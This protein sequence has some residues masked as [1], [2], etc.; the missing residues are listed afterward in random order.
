MT[1]V[2]DSPIELLV[3]RAAGGD[4]AAWQALWSM[5]E[6]LL[7]RMVGQPSFLGRVGQREDDRRNIVVDVMGRL[8]ADDFRR[9]RSYL[10]TRAANPS[11]KFMT[12]L[13][14]VTKRVGV[15]YLRGHGNYLDRRGE[16][17]ASTPG[18]WIEPGTMPSQ[19]KLP[20]ERPPM[21]DRGTAQQLLRYAAGSVPDEQRRALE[22]WCQSESYEAIARVIG[23]A[24]AGEAERAVRAAIERLRRKFRDEGEPK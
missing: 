7:L 13:R 14:V 6:P 9:L 11:L 21:T 10:D 24:T 19:S 1:V 22:M 17:N 2:E 12:W 16:A 8:R 4:A 3:L 20:G 15:D 23:V 18:V 5:V